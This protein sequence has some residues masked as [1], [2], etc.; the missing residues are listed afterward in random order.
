MVVGVDVHHDTSKRQHSVMG[1][2]ATVNGWTSY[3][4]PVTQ[5]ASSE[6]GCSGFSRALLTPSAVDLWPAGTPEW[7][8]RHPTKSPFTALEFALWQ[9]CR[10]TTRFRGETHFIGLSLLAVFPGEDFPDH[11]SVCICLLGAGEPQPARQD[12]CVPGRRVRGAAQFGGGVWD[13]TADQMFWQLP[14]LCSE[15]GFH[16]GPKTHQHHPLFLC[17]KQLWPTSAWNYSGSH[18]HSEKLVG[19]ECGFKCSVFSVGW[20]RSGLCSGWIS[21][22]CPITS[23]RAAASRHTTYRCTTQQTWL[24]TIC[25]GIAALCEQCQHVIVAIEGNLNN[26]QIP[27]L[28]NQAHFQDVPFVLELAWDHSCSGSMQVRPQTGLPVGP[29]PALGAIHP[30]IGQALLP[31]SSRSLLHILTPSWALQFLH[32]FQ[33]CSNPATPVF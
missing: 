33:K 24:Q 14:Q 4:Y 32:L 21:T 26:N 29:V 19:F 7:S 10:S 27:L 15:A 17:N 3:S 6:K 18:P 22:W 12:R 16:R 31:L 1:F 30:T 8:S 9:R 20:Y 25:R 5:I 11:Q 28:S 13:S 23:A 2:V